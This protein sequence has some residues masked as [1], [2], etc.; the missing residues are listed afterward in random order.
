MITIPA[1]DRA[2]ERRGRLR[3]TFTLREKLPN[4]WL[5]L[6]DKDKHAVSFVSPVI[7]RGVK[8]QYRIDVLGISDM[9]VI[10]WG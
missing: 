9:Q 8:I 7:R 4:V 10:V 1:S 6:R 5:G 2:C 3:D